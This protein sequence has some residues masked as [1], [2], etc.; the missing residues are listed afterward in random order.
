MTNIVEIRDLH[1]RYGD[2]PILTGLQMDFPRGKVVA[3]MGGSGSGKTTILRLIGGQL[4]PQEG[5]VEVDG[6][7]VPSLA[8]KQLYVLRRKMGM[9]F[10]NGALF[11]DMTVFD[12]VAFP[13]REHTDLDET[14]IRDLVLMKLNAVGLRNAASLKPAE[15]SGGMARRVALARAIA[16]DP[17]L[18]MYDE[19][20]AGLDPISMGVT[21][22]LIRRLNDALGSTSILVSH[23]VN[24]S[25]AIADYVYFLSAGK[26]VAQG[27]PQQMRE[28]TDPYVKQFVH[29][30]A[31]GPVPFHY[32]GKS[33][34]E[35]L[36]LGGAA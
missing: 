15:I 8:T 24:E 6:E 13:L 29:A 1:F 10:Q 12:N 18:I 34:A 4:Q 35:D 16:L 17:A 22:N 31:D 2:R 25:F 19:P 26:I 11:T 32:P 21:A 9:L 36:G 27:T 3:V 14:L 33:L 28:S 5:R 23:D 30:Q 20:F 7:N